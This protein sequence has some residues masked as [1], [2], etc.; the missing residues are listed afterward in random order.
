MEHLSKSSRKT[1]TS[2]TFRALV[3][4]LIPNTPDLAQTL[5]NA[6]VAGAKDLG[7]ADFLVLYLDHCMSV[8][9]GLTRANFPLSGPTAE[10]LNVAALHLMAQQNTSQLN[11]TSSA[12]G[13]GPFANL[14]R[15]NRLL[16]IT[17]LEQRD[18][19]LGR[20]PAPFTNN[21]AMVDN[22]LLRLHVGTVFGYYSEW[23]GYGATRTATPVRRRLEFFPPSWLQVKFPGP[24]LGCRNYGEPLLK[25]SDMRRGNNHA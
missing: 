24:G 20:L 6:Q 3:S 9:T 21:A 12:P 19:D 1:R 7:V 11:A 13:N 17:L 5:G 10:I 14:S 2:V 25:M 22:I 23:T 16:A 18:V 4:A 8:Q 15:R